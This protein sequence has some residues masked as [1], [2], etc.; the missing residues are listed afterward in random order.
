MTRVPHFFKFSNYFFYDTKFTFHFDFAAFVRFVLYN[1]VSCCIL[2][3]N[4][5][6]W[7]SVPEENYLEVTIHDKL[8]ESATLVQLPHNNC[9]VWRRIRSD[10]N[11]MAHGHH[12]P[13]NNDTNWNPSEPK[14]PS[15]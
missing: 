15:L 6:K 5:D 12:R 3:M 8:V 7:T 11:S 9:A 10:I 13:L 2:W 1:L 14:P 4:Y